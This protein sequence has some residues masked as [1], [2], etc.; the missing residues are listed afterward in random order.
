MV[1]VLNSVGGLLVGWHSTVGV[2]T[3]YE[4]EGPGDRIPVRTRFSAPVQ[5]GHE[6]HPPTCTVGT[7]THSRE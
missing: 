5:T 1:V 4:L 3:R 2:A 7:E 6:A